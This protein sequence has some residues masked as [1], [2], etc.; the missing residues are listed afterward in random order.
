MS[1]LAALFEEIL[2]DSIAWVE[3]QSE[4]GLAIGR[5]LSPD[6]L[7]DARRVGVLA[8][9]N[10]RVVVA[11]ALPLPDDG[12]LRETAVSTGLLGPEFC[13]LTLGHA[14]FI[15]EGHVSRRL[16]THECRHVR[17][18]ENAG[19]IGEFLGEYLSQI[20]RF[21]YHNAPY[22]VDARRCEID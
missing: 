14:I 18:Y 12:A 22:E 15:V 8:P 21:G 11:P 10:I 17:Q 3:A 13:G 6:E 19:S 5:P 16:L 9:E 4:V 2:P 20:A 7:A 1:N